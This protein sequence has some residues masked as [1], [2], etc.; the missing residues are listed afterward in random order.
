MEAVIDEAHKY[1]L[2]TVAH[3]NQMGVSRMTALDAAEAGLDMMTHYY[4]LFESL[5]KDLSIQ[6]WP[7]DYNYNNEQDR[8]G[9][10]ARLWIRSMNL[11]L[12]NGMP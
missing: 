10:V 11:V 4:G 9:S 6:D 7:L 12:T 1:G 3:L 2:G 8:F 5:L